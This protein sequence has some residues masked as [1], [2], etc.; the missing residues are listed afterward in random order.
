MS[1]LWANLRS[2]QFNRSSM[3]QTIAI[4]PIGST[5]QHGPHLP[6]QVDTLLATEVAQR[7]AVMYQGKQPVLVLPPLWVSLAEHHMMMAGTLSLDHAT[8]LA[9][10]RCIV[11]SLARQGCGQVLLLNGHGG[12]MAALVSVVDQLSGE[13]DVP[14]STS[15]YWVAAAEAFGEILEGQ[16]NLLHACEAET[17]MLMY[18]RPDLVDA[19]AARMLKAPASGFLQPAGS[20]RWRPIGYW[21]CSGVVGIPALATAEKGE[22]LLKAAAR[23]VAGLLESAGAFE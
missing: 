18:L 5:E 17:S 8:L 13:L 7:A 23:A 11:R 14:L 1:A 9:F 22:R 10:I 21:S 12:N 20:H 16:S 2:P 3:A 19:V 4:L 6:V 15:T